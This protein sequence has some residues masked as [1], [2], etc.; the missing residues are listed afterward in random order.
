MS[1]GSIS[2]EAD[3]PQ[4]G[5][6]FKELLNPTN[7]SRRNYATSKVGNWFLA[8]E[9]ARKFESDGVVSIALNPGNLKTPIWNGTSKLV[10]IAMRPTMSPVIFGA[11]TNMWAGLSPEITVAAGT[12]GGYVVPWGRFYVT[13]RKDL[14]SALKEEDGSEFGGQAGKF[15]NWC[16]EQT[17]R[18]T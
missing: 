18:Y 16:D 13:T 4:G 8:V 1:S 12:E 7:N 2:A 15:W 9:F 17:K 11:Y 5:V 3:S 14:L 6:D 10:Q